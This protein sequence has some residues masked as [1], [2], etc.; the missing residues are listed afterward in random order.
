MVL[1]EGVLEYLTG[2]E[3][4]TLLNR[5]T[6]HF[7]HGQIAFDVMNSYAIKAGR[8]RASRTT[9]ALHQWSVEDLE[10]VDQ[11]DPKLTRVTELSLFRSPYIQQLP[12]GYRL[13]YRCVSLF[14]ARYKNMIR[15]L[16]YQF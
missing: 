7:L 15:L 3:V 12:W 14:P 2:G 6:G 13:V 9:G 1:A 16:R 10:E 5:I 4:K 8:S 11:L